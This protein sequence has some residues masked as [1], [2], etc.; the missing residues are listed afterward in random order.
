MLPPEARAFAV[1][2]AVEAVPI[3]QYLAAGG[4]IKRCQYVQ[5]GGFAAA[6]GAHYGHEFAFVHVEGNSV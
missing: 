6:A 4:L 2:N 5:Q 1:L 3:E